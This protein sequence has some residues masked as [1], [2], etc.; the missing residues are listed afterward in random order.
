MSPLWIHFDIF[1]NLN[2]SRIKNSL[3]IYIGIQ[4]FRFILSICSLGCL[5]CTIPNSPH[6]WTDKQC[7]SLNQNLFTLRSNIQKENKMDRA[8]KECVVAVRGSQ[9][10]SILVRS[11]IRTNQGN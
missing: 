3:Q 1:Q 10:L 7:P 5:F 2:L 8:L 4:M 9:S 11:K 6:I